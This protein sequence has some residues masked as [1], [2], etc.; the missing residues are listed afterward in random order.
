MTTCP[1]CQNERMIPIGT[2]KFETT[3]SINQN[4]RVNEKGYLI[5]VAMF[6]EKCNTVYL[7]EP[8]KVYG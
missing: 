7:R 5:Y 3:P 1:E 6:C 4:F 8:Q 2:E